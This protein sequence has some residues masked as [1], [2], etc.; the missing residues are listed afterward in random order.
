MDTAFG[1]L[2][3]QTKS[4]NKLMAPKTDYI[5]Q[6][7][8]PFALKELEMNN[9]SKDEHVQRFLCF[10]DIVR[11]KSTSMKFRFVKIMNSF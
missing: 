8:K 6:S 4:T 1:T 9:M 11:L 5:R 10:K 7:C 2:W 3:T